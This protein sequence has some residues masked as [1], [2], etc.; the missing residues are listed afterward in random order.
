MEKL[1]PIVELAVYYLVE[2]ERN[3]NNEELKEKAT[4]IFD[5]KYCE[6]IDYALLNDESCQSIIIPSNIY[7]NK[8]CELWEFINFIFL[9][10]SVIFLQLN[11]LK[12]FVPLIFFLPCKLQM[13]LLEIVVKQR[14]I[15]FKEIIENYTENYSKY[16]HNELIV[17]LFSKVTVAVK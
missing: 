10:Y 12:P 9:K 3:K 1:N 16:I 13:Y 4:T 8:V 6:E 5:N 14:E 2:I 15:G 17:G 7:I 11:S